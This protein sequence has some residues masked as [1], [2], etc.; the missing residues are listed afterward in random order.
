MT[1]MRLSAKVAVYVLLTISVLIVAFPLLWMIAA[2]LKTQAE[3]IDPGAPL[4]PAH[5]QWSNISAAWHS[6]PFGRFFF[7][8][9]IFAVVTTGG[10]IGVGMLAGYAFAMF[11]FPARRVAF[12]LVMS[13]LMIP[14]TVVIVP[15]VQVLADFGWID[16][17]Q[18]LLVPNIASALGAFL[19]R[20]FFLSAPAELGEAARI[21]GA[22][23][24]RIF[25]S[26]YRPLAQPMTAAFT[27]I[28]FL[29]NWNNFLFPLLV[30]SKQSLMMISQGLTEFQGAITGTAYNLL[31][32]GSL[33]AV[34]P[35]LIVA[36]FAQRKIV[37]GLTIGAVR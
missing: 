29:G 33:I 15:F 13:G 1:G 32:A 14:F 10:Q 22:S 24:W 6:A 20:Q 17:W 23:E 28:A 8:T 30:T 11:D 18:G 7:N 21:D 4:W 25:W 3:V 19:F 16:T 35:V 5:P 9:L 36:M 12:Y 34:G 27:V 31:M 26:V 37:E 2:A